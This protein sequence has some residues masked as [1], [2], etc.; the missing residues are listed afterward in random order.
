MQSSIGFEH[1]PRLGID[2]IN[3]RTISRCCRTILERFMRKILRRL[4]WIEQVFVL[5]FD[6]RNQ[7]CDFQT[8]LL[9]EGKLRLDVDR[10]CPCRE[11]LAANREFV[12]ARRQA[13]DYQMSAFV[14]FECT[15][16]TD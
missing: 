3:D 16:N 6:G 13:T 14:R 12:A 2:E 4:D 15:V 9:L 1:P 10:D 5:H 11:T 7:G 8:D